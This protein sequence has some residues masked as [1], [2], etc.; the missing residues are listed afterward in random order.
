MFLDRRDCI[1]PIYQQI[2]DA[3]AFVLKNIRLESFYGEG[4]A[5]V[6]E[7]EIPRKVIREILTN[8]VLHRSYIRSNMPTYVAIFDD[9]IE[10]TSPGKLYGG[11]TVEQMLEGK[12]ERRNPVIG[13]I[14]AITHIS[15]GWGRGITGIIAECEE[16]GLKTPVFEEWGEDFRVILYRKPLPA[17]IPVAKEEL[18]GTLLAVYNLFAS[19]PEISMSDAARALDVSLATVKRAV[20]ELKRK[21]RL[22]RKGGKGSGLWIVK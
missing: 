22:V 3:Y 1:G 8:A 10:I 13:R 5:R 9:R 18:T 16:H 4:I 17:K 11:M 14:F 21:G 19:N 15:E 20:A 7:Y 12:T 6:D 2:E